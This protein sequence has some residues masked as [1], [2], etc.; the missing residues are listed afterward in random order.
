MRFDEWPISRR[1]LGSIEKNPSLPLTTL[2]C[3]LLNQSSFLITSLTVT[4][5]RMI[6]LTKIDYLGSERSRAD[7]E[8]VWPGPWTDKFSTMEGDKQ[9]RP[10][11]TLQQPRFLRPLDKRIES[12]QWAVLH[13]S[14]IPS[15]LIRWINF[16]NKQTN[17]RL[18][19]AIHLSLEIRRGGHLQ[20]NSMVIILFFPNNRICRMDFH[21]TQ[22]TD[23][24]MR[25]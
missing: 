10:Q 3:L 7:G 11:I 5:A 22:D 16:V 4:Q 21:K 6:S 9:N 19:Q 12:T 23:T 2:F 20:S 17:T 24:A 8:W 25:H 15:L 13:F 14:R 1:T 18:I